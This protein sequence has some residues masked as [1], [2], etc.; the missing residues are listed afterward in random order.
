MLIDLKWYVF[1]LKEL[2]WDLAPMTITSWLN[3]YLQVANIDHIV[4]AEHGF[5][6]PQYSSHAFV[7]IARVRVNNCLFSV[8]DPVQAYL[9]KHPPP[10]TIMIHIVIEVCPKTS[11]FVRTVVSGSSPHNPTRALPWTQ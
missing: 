7:Q 8:A 9:A 5:V 11:H 2:N 10:H 6:F 3:V 1:L 4:E